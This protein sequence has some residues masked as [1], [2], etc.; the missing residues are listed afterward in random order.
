M[1]PSEFSANNKR[2]LRQQAATFEE[3]DGILFHSYQG[4]KGKSLCHVIVD[5]AEKARLIKACHDGIDDGHFGRDKTLSK[6]M[7]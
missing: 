2:G 7:L 6:V 1:Y 4:S 3:K 5:P